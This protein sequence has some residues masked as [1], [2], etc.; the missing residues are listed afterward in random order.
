MVEIDERNQ[1]PVPK[2]AL[3]VMSVVNVEPRLI[4][5]AAQYKKRAVQAA[6]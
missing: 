2:S 5:K 1:G 3:Y 6:S 4:G